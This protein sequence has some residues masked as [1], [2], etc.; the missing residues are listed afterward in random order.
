ML[1]KW[2]SRT[3][4]KGVSFFC[5]LFNFTNSLKLNILVLINTIVFSIGGGRNDRSG[6]RQGGEKS[7]NERW[8]GGSGGGGGGGGSGGGREERSSSGGRDNRVSY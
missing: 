3:V 4:S 6:G 1:Q 5:K 2:F 8:S 7:R